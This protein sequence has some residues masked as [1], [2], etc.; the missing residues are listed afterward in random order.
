MLLPLWKFLEIFLLRCNWHIALYSFQQYNIVHYLYVSGNDHLT[1]WLTS[2]TIH[3]YRLFFPMT[4]ASELYSLGN[5]EICS[6]VLL[7]VVAMQCIASPWLACFIT[8]SLYLLTTLDILNLLSL[9][10]CRWNWYQGSGFPYLTETLGSFPNPRILSF[11]MGRA[12][13]L[14]PGPLPWVAVRGCLVRTLVQSLCVWSDSTVWRYTWRV[15]PWT[16]LIGSL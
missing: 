9:V 1:V 15:L 5:F 16:K 8:G 10:P 4:R 2:I 14:L 3:R 7:A 11:P 12:R 13:A 6:T